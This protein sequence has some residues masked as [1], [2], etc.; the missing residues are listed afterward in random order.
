VDTVDLVV[1]VWVVASAALG[2]RRGLAANLLSLGGFF[3][4]AVIGSR[5]APHLLSGGSN[6]TWVPA[7]GLIGAMAGGFIVQ[8]LAGTVGSAVRR[9]LLLGP[10]RLLDTAGGAVAGIAFGLALTWLAA[11]VALEQP[12]L[13]LRNDVRESSFLPALLREVPPTSVLNLLS[14]VDPLPI[15]PAIADRMLPPGSSAVLRSPAVQADRSRV[16]KVEGTACAIGI[17]GSGWVIGHD[18]VATNAHVIAGENSTEVIVNGTTPLPA[19]VE[20]ISVTNDVAILR[21]KGLDLR[22]LRMAGHD[23]SGQSVA[24]IG[25]PENGDLRM[26]AGR[27]GTPITALSQ[28]AFGGRSVWRTIVPLRGSILH[29]DSGGP[30]IDSAGQVVAMMFATDS[31]GGGGYGV[32]LSAIRAVLA[33]P[34]GHVPVTPCP[35]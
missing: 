14:S 5:I 33:S 34:F 6:S 7:A 10:L 24:L 28:G 35:N 4:G 30:V 3:A 19:T 29:G 25:Y 16:V 18:L 15:I 17:Q 11:T 20:A 8:A 32:P 23:P 1:L 22:P 31:Q 26:V 12:A 9:R 27:A 2:A 13:G 21:V